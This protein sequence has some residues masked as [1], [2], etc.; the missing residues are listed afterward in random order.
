MT[1]LNSI[2]AATDLSAP[3]RHAGERAAMIAAGKGAR[4]SR[5]ALR[6]NSVFM[7]KDSAVGIAL[8]ESTSGTYAEHHGYPRDQGQCQQ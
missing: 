6:I 5:R 2:V 8:S 3:A 1:N 7:R 4:L